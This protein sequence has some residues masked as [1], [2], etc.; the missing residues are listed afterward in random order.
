MTLKEDFNKGKENEK[1]YTDMMSLLIN[2]F[3]FFLSNRF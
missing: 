3:S 2:K 1:R